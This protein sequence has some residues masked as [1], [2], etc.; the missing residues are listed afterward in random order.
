MGFHRVDMRANKVADLLAK[1]GRQE[2][3]TDFWFNDV[4]M[5]LIPSMVLDTVKAQNMCNLNHV[6]LTS[7]G[8][9]SAD[10]VIG[11][12]NQTDLISNEPESNN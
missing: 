8:V 1:K 9:N 5:F 6:V 10:S 2:D 3:L 4:P 12:T 7:D 11:G